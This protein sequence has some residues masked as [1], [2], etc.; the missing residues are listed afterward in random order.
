MPSSSSYSYMSSPHHP[1]HTHVDFLRRSG[2]AAKLGGGSIPGDDVFAVDCCQSNGCRSARHGAA[3]KRFAQKAGV[4]WFISIS[5]ISRNSP[6]VD[7]CETHTHRQ[8][9]GETATETE[10]EK[11]TERGGKS[12]RKRGEGGG[13]TNLGGAAVWRPQSATRPQV[14]PPQLYP[15]LHHLHECL[16]LAHQPIF[17]ALDLHVARTSLSTVSCLAFT[18][19]S[20]IL[21]HT[22]RIHP[23]DHTHA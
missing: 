11:D 14:S 7:N 10:T 3:E 16:L 20:A 8:K 9:E 17:L 19:R 21:R 23:Q 1:Q 13:R 18:K 2:T 22:F 12:E 5:V 15:H 4:E 6:V